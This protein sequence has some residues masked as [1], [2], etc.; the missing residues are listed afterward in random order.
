MKG[1]VIELKSN[2]RK[3]SDTK[4][5]QREQAPQLTLI[6]Q[7]AALGNAPIRQQSNQRNAIDALVD[8]KPWNEL[9]PLM[10]SSFDRI[11]DTRGNRARIQQV[12][13]VNHSVDLISLAEWLRDSTSAGGGW[14][15]IAASLKIA[16]LRAIAQCQSVEIVGSRA[17]AERS[18]MASW[19]WVKRRRRGAPRFRCHDELRN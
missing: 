16:L 8:L 19:R 4:A 17:V 6:S 7:S 9:R 1:V 18:R 13:I 12:E 14:Q 5:Y 2:P 15:H 3:T 11:L 10:N